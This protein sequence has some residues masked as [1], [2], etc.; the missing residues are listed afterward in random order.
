[1]TQASD[2]RDM[3]APQLSQDVPF[4]ERLFRAMCDAYTIETLEQMVRFRLNQRLDRITRSGV[5]DS[6]VFG[7][8]QWADQNKRMAELVKS[9][10]DYLDKREDLAA[11]KAE[12]QVGAER[13]STPRPDQP[14]NE[15]SRLPE[16]LIA[17][18]RSYERIPILFPEEKATLAMEETAAKIGALS[19]DAYRLPARFHLSDSAGE[20][21]VAVL[22]LEKSPDPVYLRW[23][24]ERVF[25]EDP[26][27]GYR[28]ALAL[29]HAALLLDHP[30]LPRVKA[31]VQIGSQRLEQHSDQNRRRTQLQEALNVIERRSGSMGRQ[32]LVSFDEFSSALIESFSLQQLKDLLQ[33][34]IGLPLEIIVRLDNRIEYVVFYLLETADRAG[35]DDRL[36]QTAHAARPESPKLAAL[37]VK[38]ATAAGTK[39][40]VH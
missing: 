14:H 20:R 23:L 32:P 25:V 3:S 2:A 22:A 30:A 24:C 13:A 37:F 9:A 35:W 39:G 18:V 10:A 16:E 38:Y 12:Y 6:A 1:M 33:S 5:V 28:A 11:L 40:G 31:Q 19:L 17:L 29:T 26:F 15:D 4:D 36:I 27:A 7:L 21:L 8:I 34:S